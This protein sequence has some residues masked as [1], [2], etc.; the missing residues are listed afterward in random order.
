MKQKTDTSNKQTLEGVELALRRATQRARELAAKTG[1]PL[2]VM[3]DGE[4]KKI[5][6]RPKPE[7]RP[8]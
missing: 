5:W 1:T 6:I 2:V 7:K 8:K 4:I 3:V